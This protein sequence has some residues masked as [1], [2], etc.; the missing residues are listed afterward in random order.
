MTAIFWI[1]MAWAAIA[2]A[3]ALVLWCELREQEQASDDARQKCATLELDNQS[4]V[5]DRREAIDDRARA[6]R[7]LRRIADVLREENLP[8]DPS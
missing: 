6:E 8:E 3:T 4:L 5:R 1:T 2:T 7:A